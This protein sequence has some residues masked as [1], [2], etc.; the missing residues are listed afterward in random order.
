MNRGG[1]RGGGRGGYDDRRYDDGGNFSTFLT[2]SFNGLVRYLS[3]V[4]VSYSFT[5]EYCGGLKQNTYFG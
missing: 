2:I 4:S 5:H 1:G 3:Q